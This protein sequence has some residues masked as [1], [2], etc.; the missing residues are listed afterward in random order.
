M[1][2]LDDFGGGFTSRDFRRAEFG[3]CSVHD[4]DIFLGA[5]SALQIESGWKGK[6][7]YVI[8]R[9]HLRI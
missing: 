6:V 2:W 8:D 5:R 3:N 4:K 9:V 1:S 7:C